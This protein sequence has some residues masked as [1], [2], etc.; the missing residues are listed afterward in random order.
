MDFVRLSNEA[1]AGSTGAFAEMYS[2]CS[3]YAYLVSFFSLRN[4]KDAEIAVYKAVAEAFFNVRVITDEE[5]FMFWFMG[6]V[7]E[8]ILLR[9][10]E[11]KEQGVILEYSAVDE[12][13]SGSG[14]NI[15]LEMNALPPFERLTFTLQTICGYNRKQIAELTKYNEATVDAALQNAKDILASRPLND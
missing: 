15:K 4:Q 13:V 12:K 5:D 2:S 8:K 1:K 7:T 10:K 11:Y 3:D 14:V 6:Y 9:M